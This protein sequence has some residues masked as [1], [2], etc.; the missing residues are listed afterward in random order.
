MPRWIQ[1]CWDKQI[2]FS[3]FPVWNLDFSNYTC[4]L[5]VQEL[6]DYLGGKMGGM[7]REQMRELWWLNIVKVHAIWIRS[8]RDAAWNFLQQRYV[9]NDKN[10]LQKPLRINAYIWT[11]CAGPLRILSAFFLFPPQWIW[12]HAGLGDYPTQLLTAHQNHAWDVLYL[13]RPIRSLGSLR[14]DYQESKLFML[15]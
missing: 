10:K 9:N 13:S 7:G 5:K 11:L 12:A 8:C 4:D 6:S 15:V 2:W 14:K 3:F 1:I